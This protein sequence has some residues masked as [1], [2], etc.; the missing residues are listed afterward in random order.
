MPAGGNPALINTAI[1]AFGFPGD[2]FGNSAAWLVVAL[3]FASVLTDC[4]MAP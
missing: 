3:P 2:G 1:L 4:G